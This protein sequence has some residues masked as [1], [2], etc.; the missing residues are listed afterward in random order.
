MTNCARS[1]AANPVA[2]RAFR[3]DRPEWSPETREFWRQMQARIKQ[4]FDETAL[5]RALSVEIDGDPMDTVRDRVTAIVNGLAGH[6]Y[7]R[8]ATARAIDEL[9]AMIGKEAN[10]MI[11]R[12][13]RTV[14]DRLNPEPRAGGLA[15]A[16]ADHLAGQDKAAPER[17]ASGVG[18][19]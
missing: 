4:R 9:V 6:K 8:I 3:P 7:D 13:A 1:F 14:L 17:E 2:A 11:A 19:G 12:D 10:A 15:Q 5:G 18:D 16:A